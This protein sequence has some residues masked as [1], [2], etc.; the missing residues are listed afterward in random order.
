ME[1]SRN[2]VC[3]A[4]VRH[5]SSYPNQRPVVSRSFFY[6]AVF[7]R[8]EIESTCL[9]FGCRVILSRAYLS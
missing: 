8:P 7:Y 4:I 6:M 3:V 2:H 9:G 1:N 5:S